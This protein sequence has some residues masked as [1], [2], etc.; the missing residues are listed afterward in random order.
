MLTL[1]RWPPSGGPLA[2]LLPP[3]GVLDLALLLPLSCLW[4]RHRL[5]SAITASAWPCHERRPF[6]FVAVY[7]LGLQGDL[8]IL[9]PG[10]EAMGLRL[11]SHA[12]HLLADWLSP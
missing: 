12:L 6:C 8:C 4:T 7:P 2:L 11:S 3:I 1:L 9:Q 5:V 10:A